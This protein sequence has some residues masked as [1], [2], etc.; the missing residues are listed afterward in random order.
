MMHDH[1]NGPIFIV[2]APRSGTTLLQYRLRDHPKLSL[3]T[4]ESHFLVPLYVHQDKFAPLD[5]L[6]NI[7]KVLELMVKKSRKFLETDLHGM[8]FDVDTLSQELLENHCDSIPKI[9]SWIFNKNAAGEGKS[10]WGEKTPYYVLHIPKILEWFPDAQII[11]IIR[12]GRDVALS[13]FNRRHDFFM[14]NTYV[15][16][17]SWKRYVEVG[18]EFGKNLRP[19]QYLEIAYESLISDPENTLGAICNFLGVEYNEKYFEQQ[20]PDGTVKTPLVRAPMK[21]NNSEKWRAKMSQNQISVFESV[22]SKT[23][24]DFGYSITTPVK[25]LSTPVQLSYLLHNRILEDFWRFKLNKPRFKNFN[26]K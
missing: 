15:A 8:K 9:I 1:Q 19:D 10:R 4:G 6:E 16:A 20:S 17:Q 21:T 23:L 13:L 22:A 26:V 25:K 12:D 2:G 3:P 11:H 7:K 14:Y 5:N 18:H 24:S